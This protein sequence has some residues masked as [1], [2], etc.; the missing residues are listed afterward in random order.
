MALLTQCKIFV[1]TVTIKYKRHLFYWSL[2]LFHTLRELLEK[3]LIT[4]TTAEPIPGAPSW[5]QLLRRF[6]LTTCHS[7]PDLELITTSIHVQNLF[8]FLYN[9]F[10]IR[11]S[12]KLTW[13]MFLGAAKDLSKS[14]EGSWLPQGNLSMIPS[15]NQPMLTAHSREIYVFSNQIKKKLIVWNEGQC[16]T[17]TPVLLSPVRLLRPGEEWQV[18]LAISDRQCS[19]RGNAAGIHSTGV[20]TSSSSL[21]ASG[22]KFLKK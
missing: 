22:L 18:T 14:G 19:H 16:G 4:D 10:L 15:P 8:F 5:A 1:S 9:L 17:S 7:G 20:N 11:H 2:Y 21:G 3:L 13:F 12:Y 6:P